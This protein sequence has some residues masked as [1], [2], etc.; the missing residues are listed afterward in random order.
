MGVKGELKHN[1]RKYIAKMTGSNYHLQK[2]KM[3]NTW[4]LRK[5]MFVSRI[6]LRSMVWFFT[7]ISGYIL[8]W[9]LVIF[10]LDAYHEAFVHV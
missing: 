10:V 3:F 4:I 1:K 5:K 7:I 2:M 8:C 9:V 6:I